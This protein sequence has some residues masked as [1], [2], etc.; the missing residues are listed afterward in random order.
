[1]AEGG[2]RGWKEAGRAG[3]VGTGR[4]QGRV[5]REGA[6]KCEKHTGMQAVEGSAKRSANMRS[7]VVRQE[8]VLGATVWIDA[9]GDTLKT[10]L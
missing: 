10:V 4:R 7:C 3:S 5:R 6:A 8:R 9:R 2:I 1:M